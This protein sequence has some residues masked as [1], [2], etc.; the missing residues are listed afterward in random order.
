MV[1]PFLRAAGCLGQRPVTRPEDHLLRAAGIAAGKQRLSELTGLARMTMA[2]HTLAVD[3]TLA[4]EAAGEQ[5]LYVL[6]GNG[7]FRTADGEQT[8]EAGDFLALEAGEGATV[9]AASPL[10]VLTG[11]LS[12]A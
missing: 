7:S 10:T 9:Q 11:G 4:L 3:D 6:S 5:F 8:I 2:M 12:S 1:E